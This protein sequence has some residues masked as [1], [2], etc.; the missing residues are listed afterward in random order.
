MK[1]RLNEG[2]A[3]P[4][5]GGS[6]NSDTPRALTDDMAQLV[7]A[8]VAKELVASLAGRGRFGA[9]GFAA[10][11]EQSV[12]AFLHQ[13]LEKNHLSR[14]AGPGGTRL[15]Y[16]ESCKAIELANLAFGFNGWSCRV[17]ECKEEFVRVC[18]ILRPPPH[19]LSSYCMR[20]L[21]CIRVYARAANA[22]S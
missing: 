12:N 17:I 22:Q 9:V 6:N 14:R 3:A 16:I 11:E 20:I 4:M 19:C 7:A 5:T 18:R 13:K 1:R 21:R 10:P 8:M 2:A 15:T